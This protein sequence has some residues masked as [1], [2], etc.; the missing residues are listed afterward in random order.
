M[1]PVS[2][3]KTVSKAVIKKD[4]P[5]K[6]RS[7]KKSPT[8][9]VVEAKLSEIMDNPA[10]DTIPPA[11]K[12]RNKSR[13]SWW[14]VLA[15][16]LVV[17]FGAILLYE[18]NTDFRFNSNK[19]LNSLGLSKLP[20]EGSGPAVVSAEPFVMK[21][22]IVYDKDH[23][24]MKT[25]I[26]AYLKNLETNL[27]NT[28]VSPVWLDKNEAAGQALITKLNAKYL[29]LFTTEASIVKHPQYA[30]FSG[31]IKQ[32]NGEYQLESEGMEYL[33]IP[34]VGAARYIGANPATAKVVIIEYSSMSCGYCK[35]MHSILEKVV[36]TYGSQLSLV[37]KHYDRGGVDSLLGQA[38][39]CAADQN[40]IRPMLTTMYEKQSDVF[41]TLQTAENP[42]E[43]VY[44]II[45]TMATEAGA[46]GAK[47]VA[48]VKAETYKDKIAADSKEGALFGVMGTPAFFINKTFVGGATDEATFMKLVDEALKQ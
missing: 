35:A 14:G 22:T 11:T 16:L 44:E 45:K 32:N 42:Q 27:E 8:P 48:C 36:D 29:P 28:K 31:V 5:P 30:L 26:E 18:N 7:A 10:S 4:I 23:P 17:T 1:T 2:K 33:E 43:A 47:V 34:T 40:R 19:L 15:L 39:E 12:A 9:H 3:K 38:V 13:F 6:K 46:D 20:T 25:S 24:V 21:M 41:S 37:I